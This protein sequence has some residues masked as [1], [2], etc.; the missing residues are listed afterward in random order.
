M[1]LAELA[2]IPATLVLFESPNRIA[3]L[4]ADAADLLG[5][6]RAAALCREI[7]KLHETF[8]RGALGDLAARYAGAEV[9]GEIVL[10]VAPPAPPAEAS[11]ADVDALLRAAL[12]EMGVRDAARS[13]A[14]AAGLS[15]S[16][17]YR[18]ALKLKA[19]G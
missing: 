9:K 19:E 8:D 5:E 3:A 16:A 14:E 7:T 6:D 11:E 13:V 12:A 2:G 18:R 15:R 10:I 17:L 4:L 1:R